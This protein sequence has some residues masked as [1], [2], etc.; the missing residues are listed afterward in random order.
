MSGAINIIILR[1]RFYYFH[2]NAAITLQSV[3]IGDG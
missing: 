1:G 2:H 3:C